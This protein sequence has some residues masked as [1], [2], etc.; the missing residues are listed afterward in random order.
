MIIKWT[1][2]AP[3]WM[4]LISTDHGKT[5]ST[6][7][8]RNLCESAG[9]A[10]KVVAV[11]AHNA[12]GANERAH[13]VVKQIFL[14]LRSEAEDN[15]RNEYELLLALAHKAKNDTANEF[16]LIPTLLAWGTIGRVPLDIPK[17]EG[18]ILKVHRS[19]TTNAFSSSALHSLR[20]DA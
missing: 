12:I 13:G 15:T 10:L 3:V 4:R 7:T 9:V 5:F 16:G 8:F 2:V 14:K 20:P 1:C 18:W 17:L 11:E 19:A 6:D